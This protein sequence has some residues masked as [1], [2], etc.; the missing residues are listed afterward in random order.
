MARTRQI[1]QQ[2]TSPDATLRVVA[3][4]AALT[5]MTTA[6]LATQFKEL[7]GFETRSRNKTYLCKRLAWKLQERAEGGLSRAAIRRIAELGDELPERWRMRLAPAS[8]STPV[9]PAPGKRDPR[10]PPVGTVLTREFEGRTYSVVVRERGVEIDGQLSSLSAA[11]KKISGTAW[12]G[13]AFFGLESPRNQGRVMSSLIDHTTGAST[14]SEDDDGS[15][16]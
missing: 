15:Q 6:E 1:R 3:Q 11:A 5:T 4:L 10:L 8:A 2:A 13:F 14:L 7:Y 12:N 9:A 16:K